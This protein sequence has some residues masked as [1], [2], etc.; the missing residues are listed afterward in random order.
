MTEPEQSAAALAAALFAEETNRTATDASAPRDERIAGVGGSAM[1]LREAFSAGGSGM[2][3]VMFGLAIIDE[4]PRVAGLVLA[5]D[6]QE[7]FG[8]SDTAVLGMIGLCRR[9]ARVDHAARS[10]PRR[11]L[12]P[13]PAGGVEQHHVGGRDGGDRRDAERIPDG[14]LP[15]PR[16]HRRRHPGPE[17]V[18]AARRQLPDPVSGSDLRDRGGQSSASASSSRSARRGRSSRRSSVAPRRGRWVFVDR[19]PVPIT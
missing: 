8:I 6:I 16:R 17:R 11:P 9:D 2:L 5:P 13:D 14:P 15:R 19:S 7:T 12:P 1:T 3:G 4:F 18:V 10:Q